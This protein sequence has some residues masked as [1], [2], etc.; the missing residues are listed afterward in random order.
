MLDERTGLYYCKGGRIIDLSMRESLILAILIYNKNR[1]VPF[2][3]LVEEIY[4]EKDNEYARHCIRVITHNLRKKMQGEVKI[5][6][7]TG[8]GYFVGRLK[9]LKNDS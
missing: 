2:G 4:G 8:V 6:T 3:E 1:V 7:K 5:L 9:E